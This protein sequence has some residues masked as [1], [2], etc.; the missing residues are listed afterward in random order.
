MQKSSESN[1]QE[2][3]RQINAFV[4]AFNSIA[5]NAD[6]NNSGYVMSSD[7]RSAIVGVKEEQNNHEQ[8]ERILKND[9]LPPAI[10]EIFEKDLYDG[11]IATPKNIVITMKTKIDGPIYIPAYSENGEL[12]YMDRKVREIYGSIR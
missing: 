7:I 8:V 11:V 5:D 6:K 12:P 9:N 2:R 3:Q 4:D 1:R 10:I